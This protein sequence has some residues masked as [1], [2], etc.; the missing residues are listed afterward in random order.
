MTKMIISAKAMNLHLF[1]GA[2][3]GDG[4]AQS[5]SGAAEGGTNAAEP[6][7]D[8]NKAEGNQPAAEANKADVVVTS[9]ND[10]R[11]NEYH[12]LIREQYSDFYREDTQK[13]IDKR[14]AET[15][16]LEKNAKAIAP[17]INALANNY[18]VAA[19]DYEAL[20]K[21]VLSDQKLYEQ[22][23]AENGVSVET[24]M[25]LDM[26]QREIEAL[27]AQQEKSEEQEFRERILSKWNEEADA[28]REQV[29]DFDLDTA[30]ENEVFYDLLVSGQPLEVAYNAAFPEAYEKRVMAKVEKKVT[31]N[32]R[33]RGMRPNENGVSSSPT[34]TQRFDVNN[35]TAAQIRDIENRVMRGERITFGN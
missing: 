2:G 7:G 6:T 15:K 34:A 24:Q 28:F 30:L 21:A 22:R 20:T 29:S 23:A 13:L 31:D 16:T 17:M 5:G 33:S 14:F 18:G 9:D 4:G 26:Q 3:A 1:D 27:R 12:K 32:I 8:G 19:D 25:K 11:R 35:M 10:V